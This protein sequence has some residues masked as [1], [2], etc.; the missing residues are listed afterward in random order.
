MLEAICPECENTATG[1]SEI[2]EQFGFRR[3]RD[4]EYAQSWC[5]KCRKHQLKEK[6]YKRGNDNLTLF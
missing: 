4:R 2:D 1:R 5:R 3:F 6:K